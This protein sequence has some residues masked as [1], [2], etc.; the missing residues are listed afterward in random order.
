LLL[1]TQKEGTPS[2]YILCQTSTSKRSFCFICDQVWKNFRRP[3]C[4][5]LCLKPM[6]DCKKQLQITQR[7]RSRCCSLGTAPDDS[8][9]RMEDSRARDIVRIVMSC[10]RFE[11][12]IARESA[13][14]K[15]ATGALT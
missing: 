11:L 12:S 13:E 9:I 14:K 7:N 6:A 5:M 15:P 10:L 8:P 4:R 1:I 2:M 3:D